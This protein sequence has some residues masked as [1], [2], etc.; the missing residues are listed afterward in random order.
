[1]SG[2]FPVTISTEDCAGEPIVHRL[3]LDRQPGGGQLLRCPLG[4]LPGGFSIA[5]GHPGTC[6]LLERLWVC[7]R[8]DGA[9]APQM[10]IH[11]AAGFHG[12]YLDVDRGLQ[13]LSYE[14]APF[15]IVK[16]ALRWRFALECA[17]SPYLPLHG[18]VLEI[19]GKR[20]CIT[21][22]GGSGKSHLA[23]AWGERHAGVSILIEDWC[24]LE[25]PARRLHL[26]A[27]RCLH[28]R[29][30]AVGKP[31]LQPAGS[32][33]ELVEICARD[34]FSAESRYLID[35][36]ELPG[37]AEPQAESNLDAFLILAGPFTGPF[38]IADSRVA[39]AAALRGERGLFW[40]RSN[41]HLPQS[42]VADLGWKWESMLRELPVAIASGYAGE[43]VHRLIDEATRRLL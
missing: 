19:D 11:R 38:Q 20:L 24:L 40:D 31:Y 12:R 22:A 3:D 26:V 30:V 7:S 10:V 2:C 27:E 37:F 43:G 32:V 34:P 29:G 18:T 6:H 5:A 28:V 35:R 8:V 14:Y 4:P 9:P 21:G 15:T 23:E 36:H 1:M 17:G 39:V 16:Q 41:Q 33:P 13:L 42:T 25:L